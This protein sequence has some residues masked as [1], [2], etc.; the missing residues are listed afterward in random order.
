M[1]T[2][3]VTPVR[4]RGRGG[5]RRHARS[6][7]IRGRHTLVDARVREETEEHRRI[8]KHCHVRCSRISSRQATGCERE[9]E[10]TF[11]NLGLVAAP[12]HGTVLYNAGSVVLRPVLSFY[13][14]N[15]PRRTLFRVGCRKDLCSLPFVSTGPR[16]LFGWIARPLRVSFRVSFAFLRHRR[17]AWGGSHRVPCA[18]RCP[19]R[20][21][22]IANQCFAFTPYVL[23]SVRNT[24]L[25]A[26]VPGIHFDWS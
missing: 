26:S 7:G 4:E 9:K 20:S 23:R 17:V 12:C 21:R 25:R 3:P 5:E 18:W 6:R 10:G 14:T 19:H 8:L 2:R 11:K 16:T 13:W 22:S 24:Y 15:G 1:A